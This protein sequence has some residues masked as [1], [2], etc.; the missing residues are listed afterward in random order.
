VKIDKEILELAAFYKRELR[1]YGKSF[2]WPKAKNVADTYTYRS[3]RSFKLK[4]KKEYNLDLESMKSIIKYLVEY[5]NKN[6]HLDNG[7]SIINRSDIFD[8]CY[9]GMF[10]EINRI[11][12][13]ISGIKKSID[14]LKRNKMF[15]EKILSKKINRHGFSNIVNI[16]E[17][18]RVTDEFISLS[19]M[20]MNALLNSE[21]RGNAPNFR[22]LYILKFK[23]IDK[24]GVNKLKEIMGN[25]F[26]G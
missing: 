26:N 6:R 21:D 18:G 4:C 14:Y 2:K 7:V 1:R 23:I 3:F 13:V 8:I 17:S 22:N 25:D 19:K 12:N 16:R 24:I 15:N 9:N 11:D 20:C 10:L 5:A